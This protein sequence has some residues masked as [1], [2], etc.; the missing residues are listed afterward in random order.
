MLSLSANLSAS[1]IIPTKIIGFVSTVTFSGMVVDEDD[2]N[3]SYSENDYG[4]D[5]GN[6]N[7]NNN[8]YIRINKRMS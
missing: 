7:E 6:N 3:G 1:L 2:D 5:N 4:N 8:D